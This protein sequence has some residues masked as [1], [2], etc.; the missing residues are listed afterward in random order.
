MR[1]M[2]WMSGCVGG[3]LIAGLACSMLAVNAEGAGT[4]SRAQLRDGSCGGT[5]PQT[6]TV[7]QGGQRTSNGSGKGTQSRQQLRDG[8]CLTR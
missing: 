3:L 1:K 4:R 2:S 8:S 7:R 6:G 5:C